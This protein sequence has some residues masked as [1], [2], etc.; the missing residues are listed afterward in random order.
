MAMSCL[1]IC[2]CHY[3]EMFSSWSHNVFIECT[4]FC[5]HLGENAQLVVMKNAGHAINAEKPKEMLKH[6][7][8]YL[9]DPLPP[10][11]ESNGRNP[12]AE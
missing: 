2:L 11:L 5:R 7:K 9:V 12:K 4:F 8:S 3:F 6:L 10:Q 1:F